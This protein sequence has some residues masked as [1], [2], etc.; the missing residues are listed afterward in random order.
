MLAYRAQPTISLPTSCLSW[1][2]PELRSGGSNKSLRVGVKHPK[3]TKVVG[4]YNIGSGN[5]DSDKMHDML[6]GRMV[7]E[8]TVFQQELVVR[9]FDVS[10]DSK[11]SLVALANYLQDTALNHLWSCCHL[12]PSISNAYLL[13]NLNLLAATMEL[14]SFFLLSLSK[15]DAIQ[16][17]TWMYELGKN[18]LGIDWSF[19]DLKTG[20]PVIL[21]SSSY[22]MMNK[23]TRRLSKFIEEARKELKPYLMPEWSP[24]IEN[25]R[26]LQVINIDITDFTRL[27]SSPG[28]NDMDMNQHVNNAKY[29]EWILEGTPSWIMRS[30]QLSSINLE[31][32]KECGMDATLKCLSKMVGN[33]NSESDNSA[34]GHNNEGLIEVEHSLRLDS[35]L[36][37][38]RARTLWN[39]KHP[40]N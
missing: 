38:A 35:G 34:T 12:S 11:M 24:L 27:G 8:G 20:E 14:S 10:G 6:H 2:R 26:K 21:A 1:N 5:P 32:Q 29:F 31:F 9:S 19:S 3:C 39:T 16:V 22:M 30:H 4:N 33:Y 13:R 28:W 18:G 25:T 37:V 17:H 23:K 15:H 40:D 7:A 36:E